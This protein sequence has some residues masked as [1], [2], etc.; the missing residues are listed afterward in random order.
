LKKGSQY[1]DA[2]HES[3]NMLR[4]NEA[5]DKKMTA[6]YACSVPHRQNKKDTQPGVDKCGEQPACAVSLDECGGRRSWDWD[7]RLD[8]QRGQV[9][10]SSCSTQDT[11]VS[12]EQG[13]E[14]K[15]WV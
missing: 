1:K 9:L 15:R 13:G 7:P 14:V 6:T 10:H 2:G 3:L 4:R 8:A 5:T 12:G 11:R